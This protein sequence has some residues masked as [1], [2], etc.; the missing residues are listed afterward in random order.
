ME[1]IKKFLI[2]LKQSIIIIKLTEIIKLIGPNN[3]D[4]VNQIEKEIDENLRGTEYKKFSDG[5]KRMTKKFRRQNK[6]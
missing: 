1:K 3:R 2:A 5:L 4:D 6:E